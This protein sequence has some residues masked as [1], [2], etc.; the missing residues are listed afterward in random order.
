MVFAYLYLHRM[1]KS[2]CFPYILKQS[3]PC[4]FSRVGLKNG[5]EFIL[6]LITGTSGENPVSLE[7]LDRQMSILQVHVLLTHPLQLLYTMCT[8]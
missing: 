4:I 7:I 5:L 3:N 6:F 1:L 2:M 8:Q